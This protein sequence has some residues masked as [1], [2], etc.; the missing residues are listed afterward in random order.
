MASCQ[1]RD[2]AARAAA[3]S[4]EEA[5]DIAAASICCCPGRMAVPFFEGPR[6]AEAAVRRS[7]QES[8][9]ELKTRNWELFKGERLGGCARGTAAGVYT[10]HACT[11]PNGQRNRPPATW[12]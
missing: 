8:R 2:S 6:N 12:R 11:G 10:R 5:A 4:C 1:A 3:I 7:K 9:T